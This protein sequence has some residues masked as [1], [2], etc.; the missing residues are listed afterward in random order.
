MPRFYTHILNDTGFTLDEEGGEFA[1]LAGATEQAQRTMGEIIAEDLV[2]GK[3]EIRL[4]IMIDDSEG[5]RVANLRA[6]TRLVSSL[7]PFVE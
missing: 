1:D 3:S 7:N 2:A 6:T 5:L 4:T